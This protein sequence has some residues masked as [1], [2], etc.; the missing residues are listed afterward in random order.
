MARG[1]KWKQQLLCS[2]PVMLVL[3][4]YFLRKQASRAGKT[5]HQH[6]ILKSEEPMNI[7]HY[8]A[9]GILQT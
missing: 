5:T 9:Q 1:L 7:F 3:G 4:E 8:T 6:F 2:V